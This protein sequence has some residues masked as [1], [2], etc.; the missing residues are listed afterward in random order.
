VEGGIPL[1]GKYKINGSNR[2]AQAILAAC[3]C[4]N[5]I[6]EIIGCP[7]TENVRV[8]EKVLENAG[9]IIHKNEHSIVIDSGGVKKYDFSQLDMGRTEKNIISSLLSEDEN[10]II[11]NNCIL[12]PEVMDLIGFLHTCGHFVKVLDNHRIAVKRGGNL[13]NSMYFIM[14]DRTEAK[15]YMS[16]AAATGGRVIFSNINLNNILHEVKKLKKMGAYIRQEE[17]LL[18]VEGGKGFQKEFYKHTADIENCSKNDIIKKVS[19][20]EYRINKTVNIEESIAAVIEAL[21]LEGHTIIKEIDYIERG[22]ADFTKGLQSLG[23]KI[24]KKRTT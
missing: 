23:G 16:A 7:N 9:C 6:Y 22:F 18:L 15:V 8:I 5:S 19:C 20:N 4:G 11:L 1:R 21:A 2:S 14:E 3:L 10:E 12:E 17:D 24:E 13:N